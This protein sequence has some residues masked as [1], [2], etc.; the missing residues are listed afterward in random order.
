MLKVEGKE[1]SRKVLSK[2]D[3]TNVACSCADGFL[4]SEPR[5]ST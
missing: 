2:K 5:S 1:V 3:C 4:P